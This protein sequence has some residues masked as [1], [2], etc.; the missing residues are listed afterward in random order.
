M[1]IEKRL[2]NHAKK[3]KAGFTVKVEN[4]KIVPVIGTQKERYSVAGDTAI[5]YTPKEKSIQN[6]GTIK[7]NSYVGGW[8]DKETGKY[9]IE[10]VNLYSNQRHALT[11]AKKR[12]QKAIFDL[13]KMN[14]I[15]VRYPKSV[16]VTGMR[17]KTISKKKMG[18]YSALHGK[19][20][21]NELP[22]NLK[23]IPKKDILIRG[24]IKGKRRR[25][26]LQHEKEEIKLM[27]KGM[28]YKSAHNKTIK[29][30]RER[31][32]K[33][34]VIKKGNRYYNTM[35]GKYVT[36]KTGAKLNNY[37]KKHPGGTLYQAMGS[38][39]YKKKTAWPEQSKFIQN[40]Y[41]KRKTHVVKTRDR[42]GREVYYN[43][44]T[45]KRVNKQIMKKVQSMDFTEGI[46]RVQLY[47]MATNSQRVYHILKSKVEM[48]LQDSSDVDSLY[49]LVRDQWLH[50]AMEI[51]PRI[52][53]KYKLSKYMALTI[54]FSH[55]IYSARNTPK[56]LGY[57]DIIRYADPL[58]K[59]DINSLPIGLKRAMVDYNNYLMKYS[60]IMVKNITIY[61]S[62]NKPNPE[63]LMFAKNRMGVINRNGN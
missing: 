4:G 7:D 60:I 5:V 20:P 51:I 63:A 48:P 33:A 61:I 32:R 15:A 29:I 35:T 30:M 54:M 50:R 24:N 31:K 6:Y 16:H 52:A 38:P 12:K 25:A 26:I 8:F 44:L 22:K 3:N 17:I 2:L 62:S 43:P 23:K 47:R 58:N 11:V 36:K 42:K 21:K 10:R 14:E 59:A 55:E 18:D 28:K 41:K 57:V 1:E 34:P 56:T 46:F 27:D 40:I 13:V 9:L 37:F 45:G 19:L 39:E 49:G 53:E